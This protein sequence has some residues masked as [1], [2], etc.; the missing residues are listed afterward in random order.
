MRFL[1]PEKLATA[2]LGL[3][4]IGSF[5]M[6]LSSCARNGY[7]CNGRSKYITRVK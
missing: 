6:I 3:V 5:I 2:L 7:G 1:S 4:M